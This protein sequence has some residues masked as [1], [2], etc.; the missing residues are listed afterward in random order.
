M[1]ARVLIV[2]DEADIRETLQMILSYEGFDTVLAA[3]GPESLELVE[4]RPP[5]LVFLDIKMP[6]T[7]GLEVL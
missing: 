2:D 1:P 3:S 7:D 5:D 4:A 6:G